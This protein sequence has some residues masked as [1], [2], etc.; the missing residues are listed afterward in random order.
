MSETPRQMAFYVWNIQG[1]S[2][3]QACQV[4]FPFR[5][6]KAFN[7][8]PRHRVQQRQRDL[9]ASIFRV[10]HECPQHRHRIPR[11]ASPAPY[12]P[13][14]VL[15]NRCSIAATFVLPSLMSATSR[16]AAAAFAVAVVALAR[17][18]R[19]TERV[20]SR[21][22]IAATHSPVLRQFYNGEHVR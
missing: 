9:N 13:T 2:L 8:I 4:A 22:G 6:L 3:N 7:C 5:V 17:T 21:F 12:C 15:K 14:A 11:S 18:T 1:L 10:A 20:V 16:F 19:T